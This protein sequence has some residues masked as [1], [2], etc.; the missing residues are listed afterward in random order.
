MQC[1]GF[2]GGNL[3]AVELVENSLQCLGLGGGN[4]SAMELVENSLQCLGLGG[5]NSCQLCNLLGTACSVWVI[6]SWWRE[7]LSAV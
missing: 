5:G 1:L 6:T 2:G 4:L 7:L 3:S